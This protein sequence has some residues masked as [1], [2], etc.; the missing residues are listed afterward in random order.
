MTPSPIVAP[1]VRVP[2]A[3]PEMVP[4]PVRRGGEKE[5]A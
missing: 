1:P 2:E 4:V 5:V 3:V